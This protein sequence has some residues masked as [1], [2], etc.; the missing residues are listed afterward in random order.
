[1]SS[2]NFGT[3]T[4]TIANP[5]TGKS[6]NFGTKTFTIAA[7]GN[8][9]WGL[10]M[11][12]NELKSVPRWNMDGDI[13]WW[14]T[15]VGKKQSW[16]GCGDWLFPTNSD[17][18]PKYTGDPTLAQ[19][20]T[21]VMNQVSNAYTIGGIPILMWSPAQCHHDL[22]PFSES[23]FYNTMFTNGTYDTYFTALAAAMKNDGREVH[24]RMFHEMNT[25]G[26]P[27]CTMFC[28]YWSPNYWLNA[29]EY[30]KGA[31]GT[32]INTSATFKAMWQHIVSIFRNAGATN[33]KF[34][35]SVGDWINS[36]YPISAY[37]PGD[38]YVDYIGFEIYN[39]RTT[40]PFDDATHTYGSST[41]AVQAIYTVLCAVSSVRPMVLA[42][43]GCLDGTSDTTAKPAWLTNVL[44]PTTLKSLFPRLVGLMYWDDESSDGTWGLR[45]TVADQTA[46]INAF[47]LAG[48]KNGI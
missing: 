47:K 19:Q 29:T 48:F 14:N 26:Y 15:Q 1:M 39:G 37:Y 45:N 25:V 32:R 35:F 30:A 28:P 31:N 36:S 21:S 5:S 3:K 4:F 11:H 27:G 16:I 44:N 23:L 12:W 46:A 40:T 20:V 17:G 8:F 13:D 24:I 38:T 10:W 2:C 41:S 33:V 22:V 34:W 18:S 7:P 9:N 42:E 43:I 6:C